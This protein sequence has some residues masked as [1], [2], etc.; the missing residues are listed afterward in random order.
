MLQKYSDPS[1]G[2]DKKTELC[3]YRVM[4]G[5][6]SKVSRKLLF[7]ILQ[8]FLLLDEE[9]EHIKDLRLNHSI[10][11][12]KDPHSDWAVD[13]DHM[14]AR[15]PMVYT[16]G[17]RRF[18]RKRHRS[19]TSSVKSLLQEVDCSFLI[20]PITNIFLLYFFLD[21]PYLNQWINKSK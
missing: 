2:Y 16:E 1:V 9:K 21:F 5:K 12:A 18:Q 10:N 14:T 19:S 17:K 4:G 6:S 13:I 11:F 3:D 20:L 8:S 15:W 7:V